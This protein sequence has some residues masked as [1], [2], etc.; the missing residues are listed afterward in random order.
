MMFKA[1]FNI[2]TLLSKNLDFRFNTCKSKP[3]IQTY[4]IN[5][6]RPRGTELTQSGI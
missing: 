6:Y 4:T 3:N 5:E 2:N 1:D